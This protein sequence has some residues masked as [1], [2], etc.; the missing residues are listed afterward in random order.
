MHRHHGRD[1][2]EVQNPEIRCYPYFH[3]QT[4]FPGEFWVPSA[5]HVVQRIKEQHPSQ[6][7][8]VPA[9]IV[10]CQPQL[11]LPCPRLSCSNLT[12]CITSCSFMG[13]SLLSLMQKRNLNYITTQQV[14]LTN[15]HD[16]LVPV[17]CLDLWK[18]LAKVMFGG[19]KFLFRSNWN[20]GHRS[21]SFCRSSCWK[22]LHLQSRAATGPNP[23]A[24]CDQLLGL[25]SPHAHNASL[26]DTTQ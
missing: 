16:K 9:Y 2:D 17:S 25:S 18:K 20:E 1:K 10:T 22:T 3:Q 19:S 4:A 15:A 11:F 14:F 23:T 21:P 13:R 24:A 7:G 5:P 26:M 12:F 8:S 6:Q